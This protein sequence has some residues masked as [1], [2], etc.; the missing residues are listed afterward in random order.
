MKHFGKLAVLGAALAVSTTFAH[1]STIALT[2]GL[3]VAGIDVTDDSFTP[4]SITFQTPS[5]GPPASNAKVTGATGN[6]SIFSGDMA[7]MT[8]FL[9]S[10]TN[11]T[12]FTDVTNSKGLTFE[13]LT[14][15][16]WS[17][18]YLGAS[19]TSL[20]IAGTGEF[21]DTA[22][23]TPETGTYILTSSD[24]QC[25]ST[26]CGGTDNV[27]FTFE[28]NTTPP[29]TIPE[30]G[31]LMLLGTGLLGAGGMLMRRRRLSA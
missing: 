30:P 3:T 4:T 29:S 6:L 27:G 9:S 23:D 1:A 31:S 14:I 19:G 12:I 21:F 5:G 24:T 17:D 16:T 25:K 7:I 18:V 15:S 20:T 26:T 2:G 13:L 28:P 8:S 10:T 11:T 22:G